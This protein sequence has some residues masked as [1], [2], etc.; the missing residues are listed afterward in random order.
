MV[1]KI[2][3]S[4]VVA[5]IGFLIYFGLSLIVNAIGDAANFAYTSVVM[6]II[7]GLLII[8]VCVYIAR[9]WG[10]TI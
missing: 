7:A 9:L 2:L 6:A 10:V 3:R 4:I 8:G 5:I 1:D